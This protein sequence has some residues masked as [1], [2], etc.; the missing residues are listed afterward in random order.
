ME[1]MVNLKINGIAVSVPKGST[2]LD[3]A[4]KTGI[5]I[6]TLCFMKEKNEIGA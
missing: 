5:E 6:P 2:I 4:R 1:N 3:A